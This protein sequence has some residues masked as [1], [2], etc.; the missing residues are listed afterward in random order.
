VCRHVVRLAA[1][2]LARDVGRSLAEPARVAQGGAPVSRTRAAL[3]S[4]ARSVVTRVGWANLR[5]A[6]E[7]ASVATVCALQASMHSLE[8]LGGQH[9]TATTLRLHGLLTI[10]DAET[11]REELK[12]AA[13]GLEPGRLAR[14]DLS[15]VEKADGAAIAVLMESQ[16]ALLSRRV[17]VDLFGANADI[18]ELLGV[19]SGGMSRAASGRRRKASANE[20]LS[21]IGRRGLLVFRELQGWFA[22]LGATLVAAVA[23]VRKPREQN[24]RAVPPLMERAGAGAAP[25][26][27]TI[28]FFVGIVAAYEYGLAALPLGATSYVP[29]FVGLSITRELGPLMT[30]IVVAGRI[31]ASFTAELGTTRVSEEIDG[32]REL[33]LDPIGFLV[34]PR[35]SAIVLTLPLLALM[36]DAAGAL[37][38]LVVTGLSLDVSSHEFLR[39]L[40]NAVTMR[41]IVFGLSKSA[42]FGLAI[43][44]I[45]CR[46]GLA[47]SGGAG[48][49]ARRT[50][51]TVV[52]I[53]LATVV[54][55]A[56]FARSF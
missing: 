19:F 16:A 7:A 44:F 1:Q 55:D 53:L 37:G 23:V 31:G 9:G 34:L 8:V 54:I 22:F 14:F 5:S 56:L 50:A 15:S 42:A 40:Q 39:G 24:W 11:L 52:S 28:N 45:A 3:R 49:V 26:V 27:L 41:D 4:R 13:C 21:R 32:L 12:R 47:V 43:A 17:E 29:S 6:P 46:Q 35:M 30:A 20:L 2:L 36:A 48:A 33:G 10:D 25:I 18:A 38:G 51:A